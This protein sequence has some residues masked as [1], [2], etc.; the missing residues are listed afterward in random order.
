MGYGGRKRISL[1]NIIGDPFALATC[2]IAIL[3]WVIAFISSIVAQVTQ[4]PDVAKNAPFQQFSWWAIVYMLFL[5][6]GVTVVIAA[7]AIQTYHVAI[8]GYVACGL[9]L[10]SSAVNSVI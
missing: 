9:V 5:V 8:V 10:T 6:V 7:D 3:A 1:D 4:S 2:S